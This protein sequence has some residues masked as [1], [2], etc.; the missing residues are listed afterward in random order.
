MTLLLFICTYLPYYNTRLLPRENLVRKREKIFLPRKLLYTKYCLW[1][2][3]HLHLILYEKVLGLNLIQF[4]YE[5]FL[6]KFGIIVYEVILLKVIYTIKLSSL[7][8]ATTTNQK[9]LQKQTVSRAT[10]ARPMSIDE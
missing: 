10:S 3:S 1:V 9:Q 6:T 2:F 7:K 8:V 4:L 5:Y